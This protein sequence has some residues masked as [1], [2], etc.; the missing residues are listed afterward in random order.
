MTVLVSYKIGGKGTDWVRSIDGVTVGRETEFARENPVEVSLCAPQVPL[1]LLGENSQLDFYSIIPNEASAIPVP[2]HPPNRY[3]D[4][5]FTIFIV[6]LKQCL[7]ECA[8]YKPW[9]LTYLL[10][11]LSTY[12]ITYLISY[13][14]TCLLHYLLPY[15]RSY[16][17]TCLHAYLLAYLLM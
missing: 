11:Y 14:L 16:F 6:P 4:W 17:L 5:Y 2:F 10:T 13:S 12:L 7:E 8:S 9:T 15:L 3:I 1:G